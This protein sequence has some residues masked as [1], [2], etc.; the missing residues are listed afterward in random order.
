MLNALAQLSI[1]PLVGCVAVG[2]GGVVG[3]AVGGPGV[4]VAVGGPAVKVGVCDRVGVK[5]AVGPGGVDVAVGVAVGPLPWKARLKV[6]E[7][8]LLL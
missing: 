1:D 6:R 3:V 5:D 7:P 2:V 8:P 4:N